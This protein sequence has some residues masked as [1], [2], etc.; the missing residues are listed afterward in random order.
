MIALSGPGGRTSTTIPK[1]RADCR[2]SCAFA[3]WR[4]S[5]PVGTRARKQEPTLRSAITNGRDILRD[6]AVSLKV[7]PS[8]V[9]WPAFLPAIVT[10]TP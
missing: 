1:S 10:S 8:L 3:M 7:W 2:T 4:G 6:V 5:G 9:R